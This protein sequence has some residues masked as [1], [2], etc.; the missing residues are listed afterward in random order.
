M[1]MWTRGRDRLWRGWTPPSHA[2][3]DL[4][5]LSL[6]APRLPRHPRPHVDVVDN[7][8]EHFS[9]LVDGHLGPSSRDLASSLNELGQA[10]QLHIAFEARLCSGQPLQEHLAEGEVLGLVDAAV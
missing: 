1:R 8:G 5:A 3:T 10:G 6:E 7:S 4:E 2:P 9:L